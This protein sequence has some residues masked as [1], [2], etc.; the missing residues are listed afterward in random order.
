MRPVLFEHDTDLLDVTA[1]VCV[2]LR[3]W[4]CLCAQD[5]WLP[6]ATYLGVVMASLAPSGVRHAA[7]SSRLLTSGMA[8]ISAAATL[9][10]RSRF[11]GRGS[12]ML[13]V[14]ATST[15]DVYRG[16]QRLSNET[17]GLS[18]FRCVPVL[19]LVLNLPHRSFPAGPELRSDYRSGS[20]NRVS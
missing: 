2:E 18:M 6:R 8:K 13:A 19:G 7:V 3:G 14:E 5:A 10:A 9:L 12:T 4:G 20:G 15:S 1:W 11:R 16:A 17:A